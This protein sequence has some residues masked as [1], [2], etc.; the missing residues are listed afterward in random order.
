MS[1]QSYEEKLK[2]EFIDQAQ[3]VFE[4]VMAEENEAGL[5]LSEIE[6]KVEGLRFELTSKLVESKLKLM[7]RKGQG[8]AGRCGGCGREMRDKGKKKRRII[9]SQGEIEIERSYAHCPHC[10]QGL[11]SLGSTT[12]DQ[13]STRLE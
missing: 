3:S 10:G 7:V 8:P 1:Q 11:F 4:R 13:S 2:R 12:A 5:S 6:E 9:T